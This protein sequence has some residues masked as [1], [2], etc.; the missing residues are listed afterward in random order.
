MLLLASG[1]EHVQS[2]HC[3]LEFESAFCG[4]RAR[5]DALLVG[6]EV[7]RQ[8]HE[9]RR[10]LEK[11]VRRVKISHSCS[12]IALTNVQIEL[13]EFIVPIKEYYEAREKY[14]IM[15]PKQREAIRNLQRLQKR[16]KPYI[17]LDKSVADV[18]QCHS[19]PNH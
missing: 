6:F 2:L 13:L 19:N 3:A 15:K 17:D 7:C 1:G 5:A 9:E 16:H 14:R 11:K 4:G 12:A 8:R 10:A 18:P